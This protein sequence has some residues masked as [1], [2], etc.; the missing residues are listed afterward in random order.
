MKRYFFSHDRRFAQYIWVAFFQ[1]ITYV[2][3]TKVI[4]G[5]RKGIN[6]CLTNKN[7][8]SSAHI[9]LAGCPSKKEKKMLLEDFVRVF[10]WNLWQERNRR[11]FRDKE[12]P[13]FRF[14]DA[15]V[16]MIVTWCK[17]SPLFHLV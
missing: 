12:I 2:F 6:M 16:N 3:V 14:T 17:C 13:F 4:I 10:Y 15:M 8:I 11:F 1:T 7:L 5:S 9:S